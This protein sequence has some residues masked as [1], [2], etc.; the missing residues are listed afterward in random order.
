MP[1]PAPA[2]VTPPTPP[3]DPAPPAPVTP[4]AP[5]TPPKADPPAPKEDDASKAELAAL[6]KELKAFK[7]KEKAAA[8]AD[9][10][11]AEKLAE[12]EKELADARRETLV[13]RVRR[14]HGF[15]DKVYDAVV[16]TGD[17]EDDIKKAYEAHKAALDEYLKAQGVKPAPGV[18]TG[19]AP[20]P[21]PAKPA[22]DTRPYLVKMGI[23]KP[24][25]AV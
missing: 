15:S 18:G 17:T 6:K 2:P 1:D 23:V 20:P 9:K 10:T 25:Q 4:P 24:K 5:A 19:G 14:A 12:R 8:D 16:A 11:A 22:A 7:D 21:D 3:A 13:E